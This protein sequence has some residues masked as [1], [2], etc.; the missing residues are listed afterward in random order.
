MLAR[1]FLQLRDDFGELWVLQI[2]VVDFVRFAL[3][4]KM[5]VFALDFDVPVAQ[6][7]QAIGFVGFNIFFVA[8]ANRGFL[9]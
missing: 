4:M 1:Q 7:G 8:D 3:E 2:N 6:R 9:Q 5:D